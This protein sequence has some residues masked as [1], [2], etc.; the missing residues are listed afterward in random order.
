MTLQEGKGRVCIVR[1]SFYPYELNVKREA[2]ALRDFGFQVTVICLRERGEIAWENID[3][4]EVHRLPVGHR[5]GRISRYLF[6]YNAFFLLACWQLL[7]LHLR[8]P[9]RFVQVNTMPDYLVFVT[10]LPKLMGAKVILHMHEPMPELFAT[11]FPP[12]CACIFLPI[13]KA[14]ERLSLAY[15]DRALTVTREMRDNFGRRGA[16]VNK[17]TVVV[18]VPDERLF[19]GEHLAPLRERVEAVRRD[20]KRRG[21][22]RVLCHGAVEERYGVD[23]VVRAVAT[24]RDKLPGVQFR[25]MGRG[26]YLG[27]VL[28]LAQK[29][30]VADRVHYL[31]FVPF[32]VMVEEILAA[33]VAVVPVKKNPYSVLI[34]TNKMFEYIALDRPV[35]ASRLDSV[36]SYFDDETLLYFEPGDAEDLAEKIFHAYAHPEEM[37]R[38]KRKTREVYETYRWGREKKKYLSVY[39]TL[40][41]E[42][43]VD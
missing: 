19:T 22:F 3:G 29:L 40:M 1:H 37:E 2:E 7:R 18:N 21:S 39:R 15:A 27:E 5:R 32:A 4:I 12:R 17:I 35:V 25:F 24:L 16:D 34:H 9:F 8:H 14:S 33:D 10:L 38:R 13:I 20:E 6:E 41:E 26:S 42:G 31:G 11:M 28:T 23:L 30:K 36:C 43:A